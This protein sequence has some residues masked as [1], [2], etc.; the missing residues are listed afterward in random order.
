MP[1]WNLKQG[2]RL[3]IDIYGFFKLPVPDNDYEHINTAF[4]V[5]VLI[6]KQE[7]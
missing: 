7:V 3:H 2:V 4:C 1:V 5:F 6:P